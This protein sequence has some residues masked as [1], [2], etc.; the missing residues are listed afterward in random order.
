MF[1]VLRVGRCVC[2]KIIL[3]MPTASAKYVSPLGN[4]TWHSFKEVIRSLRP[5]STTDIPLLLSESFF[6]MSTQE[7][8]NAYRKCG[9]VY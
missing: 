1:E 8:E 7:I 5:L 9:L 4:S 3:H 2:V 6:Q